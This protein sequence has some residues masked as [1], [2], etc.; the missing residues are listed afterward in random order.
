VWDGVDA[1]VD[2]DHAAA[3]LA[4][5][6]GA[7]AL[8]LITGVDAV[9]LDF[10][11][12]TQRR[13]TWMDS[14]EAERHLTDGQFPAGSMGPKV[15][16]SLGFVGSGTGRMAV[17]TTPELVARTLASTDPADDAVGTRIVHAELRQGVPA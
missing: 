5:Q 11:K 8:V 13:V 2:K 4:H 15:A 6:L 9:Q 16:A 3:G 10:G 1:V 12:A 17:I 7:D 14:A